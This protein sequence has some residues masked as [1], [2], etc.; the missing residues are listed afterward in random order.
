MSVVGDVIVL[1]AAGESPETC[2]WMADAPPGVRVVLV[3]PDAL[4]RAVPPALA[5]GAVIA[6]VGN[7]REAH[8]ALALGVDEVVRATEATSRVLAA[9]SERAR[10]RA[11]GR[12]A[13]VGSSDVAAKAI[14]LLSASVGYRLASPLAV[15]SRNVEILRTAMGAV[16]GLADAYARDAVGNRDLRDSEARRVVAL[17]ASAPPTPELHATVNNLAVALREATTAVAHVYSLVAPDGFDA[18][19]DLSTVVSEVA[20]L[21]RVVVERVAGLRVQ[22]P[23]NEP[24]RASVPRSIVVQALSTLITNALHAVR[25]RPQGALITVRVEPRVSAAIV[26]VIDNGAGMAPATMERAL[27]PFCFAPSGQAT[28][29]SLSLMAERVRRAGGDIVLESELGL[30]TTVRLFLPLLLRGDAL[31]PGAN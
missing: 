7:D 30:G 12:D 6:I 4:A 9:A 29:L 3:A 11:I 18:V 28:G 22:L 10:L 14:E 13:R 8:R 23:G 27:E 21:V 26:E 5:R 17:R 24:C 19:C 16:A 31:D 15:A 25:H 2:V 1:W 20:Q